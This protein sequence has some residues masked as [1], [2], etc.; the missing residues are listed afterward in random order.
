[1]HKE[2]FTEALKEEVQQ[3]KEKAERLERKKK[4][5]SMQLK[6]EPL[7]KRKRTDKH[8]SSTS[9]GTSLTDTMASILAFSSDDE[10]DHT[11]C[12][13]RDIIENY[14]KERRLEAKEESLKWWKEK[15]EEFSPLGK[16]FII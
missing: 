1:M 14:H 5:A 2:Q 15:G 8:T 10:E 6:N 7:R 13:S 9:K 4:S 3:K 12:L 16:I 11:T